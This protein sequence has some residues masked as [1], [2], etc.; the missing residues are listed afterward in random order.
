MD[1]TLE[2]FESDVLLA[3]Q[4]TPVVLQF[5]A[6]W[7]GPCKTLKP[8]LEKLEQEYGGRFRLAKVN[9]DDNPEIAAHFQVRS[10]PFVVAFVD[11]RPADHFMGLLPEGELRAW[12]DRFVPPAEDAAPEDEEALA[13]PE[14]DPASP[15]ELA[16]A[17]KVAGAPADLAARLALARL[18]IE[19]GAWADAMDELLEIV[20]RD[21][22]FENDI[23]RVTMLD[24]F[25]KAA[26]QPQL[27]AQ[28]RRRLSTLLF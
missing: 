13:P 6:P 1:I 15:E 5:W 20:A 28:Y 24:V 21:R 9:S 22:S 14:P 26:E 7:C 17:Q 3:S 8:V 23:G 18:R 4:Q 2:N 12:L 11:G 27:V 19:R 10:I 25:E 16:L